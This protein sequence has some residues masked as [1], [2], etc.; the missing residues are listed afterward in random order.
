[1][2]NFLR[3]PQLTAVIAVLFIALACEEKFKPKPAIIKTL[4]VI[5][6]TPYT[7]RVGARLSIGKDLEVQ[8]SG[9][10]WGIRP[11]PTIN[12]SHFKNSTGDI[13]FLKKLTK[14]KSGTKYYV[15]AYIKKDEQISY[16]EELS[17]VTE[18]WKIYTGSVRLSTQSEVNNFGRE[19]YTCIVGDLIV[20]ENI[21][22]KDPI[23]T[24]KPLISIRKVDSLLAISGNKNLTSLEGLNNINTVGEHLT[25]RKNP[26]FQ[27]LMGL[28]GLI[29]VGGSIKLLFNPELESLK[30]LNNLK[31]VGR[32]IAIQSNNN[33]KII[34]AFQKIE[35][36]KGNLFIVQN[37]LLESLEGLSS[38]TA[39]GYVRIIRNSK[40]NDLRGLRSLANVDEDFIVAENQIIE[41]LEGL[42]NLTE[43]GEKLTLH[44]NDKLTTCRALRK[45]EEIKYISICQNSSLTTLD[46][47]DGFKNKQLKIH[48]SGNT[49]LTDFCSL[50]NL[51]DNHSGEYYIYSNR[52][53]PTKEEIINGNCSSAWKLSF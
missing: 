50:K 12:D 19:K 39:I 13:T 27:N 38:V 16:G 36:I 35:L 23:T 52:Y 41:S 33:L 10:C 14:L 11:L 20:E 46:G 8:E 53:N 22:E 44:S 49:N 42:E 29:S 24:L 43:I 47:L 5:N 17:F 48:I 7:A 28:Q 18:H 15:R 40:L 32:S 37:D 26:K 9:V 3:K 4:P 1:M 51:F 21:S 30:G 25:I 45:V 6:I 31:S 2:I 34:D